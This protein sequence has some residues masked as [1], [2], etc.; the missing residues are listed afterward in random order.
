MGAN[1]STMTNENSTV[2]PK[3]FEQQPKVEEPAAQPVIKNNRQNN[4]VSTINKITN[5]ASSLVE[6]VTNAITPES[7]Q[8]GNIS[9][10]APKNVK[11]NVPSANIVQNTNGT[12]TITLESPK[13]N[14]QENKTT[15]NV[16]LTN[17]PS[18]FNNLSKKV[19][20][21][22]TSTN[23]TSTLKTSNSTLPTSTNSLKPKNQLT[24]SSVVAP[25]PIGE[26]AVLMQGGKRRKSRSKKTKKT[27]SK[28]T[29]RSRSRK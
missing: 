10:N 21:L 28:K 26:P 23:S 4:S 27:K 2:L 16:K 9:L 1:N 14:I 7:L 6:S 11:I 24:D 22:T 15:T 13:I 3:F 19:S 18:V 12:A 20:N 8:S 25:S 17:T 29:K 5:E